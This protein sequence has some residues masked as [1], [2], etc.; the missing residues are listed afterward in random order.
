MMRWTVLAVCSQEYS[1][2][3]EHSKSRTI[4]NIYWISLSK[5]SLDIFMSYQ[6]RSLPITC[7]HYSQSAPMM[8]S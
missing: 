5:L 2:S 4:M 1:T 8:I 6:D 7:R 3:K